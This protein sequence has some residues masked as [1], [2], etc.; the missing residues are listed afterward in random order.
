ML[1]SVT[2][3]ELLNGIRW[4]EEQMIFAIG[5]LDRCKKENISKKKKVASILDEL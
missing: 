4:F 1:K 5:I 2:I 3:D